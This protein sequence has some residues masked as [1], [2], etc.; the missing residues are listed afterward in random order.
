[1][2]NKGFTLIELLA[3]IVILAIIA[4][5]A[6]PIILGIINDSKKQSE[7]RSAELYLDAA[8]KAI[9]RYQANNPDVDFS[10][11][12]TCDIKNNGKLDCNGIDD[13]IPVEIS[14]QK[15]NDG[16]KVLLSNGNVTKV[17]NLNLGG[18]Y[19][20][21]DENNRLVAS[22]TPVES[23][24]FTGTVYRKSSATIAIGDSIVPGTKEAY[25]GVV[26]GTGTSCELIS[27]GWDTNE[28]CETE[29]YTLMGLVVTCE[30]G[31]T[32]TGLSSYATE[33]SEL[34]IGVGDYY[35]RHDV[36]NDLV[37]ASYVC[38]KY[39]ENEDAA[40]LQ[41]GVPLAY[42][43]YTGMTNVEVNEVTGAE[44][45]I[46]ELEKTR[47]YFESNEGSC[48]FSDDYSYCQ[49]EFAFFAGEDGEV[50]AQNPIGTSCRITPN[51]LAYCV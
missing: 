8:K 16:G 23:Q 7:D 1:M 49:G 6:T 21:T 13:D 22:D 33:E 39:A 46:A 34:D 5:I 42:G 19:Y 9:A 25:C 26:P 44:G 29:M 11:V 24:T 15:P 27:L 4:L 38:L 50:F 2:K 30:L 32:S 10:G 47:N 45:N 3:V 18:K 31:T 28:D 17:E 43:S 48:A 41:G 20:N 40:C 35:L 36:E 14:G 51:G 12:T 37:T